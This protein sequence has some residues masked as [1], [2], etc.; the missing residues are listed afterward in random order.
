M[1]ESPTI[2]VPS[3]SPRVEPVARAIAQGLARRAESRLVPTV[4]SSRS[5]GNTALFVAPLVFVG[6]Q[7]DL[8][9]SRQTAAEILAVLRR[10]RPG[11]CSVALFE[12][13]PPGSPSAW[14]ASLASSPGDCRG[15]RFLGPT[16]R[17]E[18]PAA[19]PGESPS[20]SELDRARRWAAQVYEEWRTTADKPVVGPFDGDSTAPPWSGWCGAL[21]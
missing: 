16:E 6:W 11:A 18:S 13:S 21:E 19:R 10:A 4:I 14:S 17:F 7:G 15:L 12:S 8:E 3:N 1:D 9:A 5:L 20:A 2:L